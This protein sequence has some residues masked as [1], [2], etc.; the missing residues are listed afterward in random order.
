MFFSFPNRHVSRQ[1]RTSNRRWMLCR[2]VY[3]AWCAAAAVAEFL[4]CRHRNDCSSKSLSETHKN[5]KSQSVYACLGSLFMFPNVSKRTCSTR[6][7]VCLKPVVLKRPGIKKPQGKCSLKLQQAK[8]IWI[9]SFFWY[10]PVDLQVSKIPLRSFLWLLLDANSEG[11]GMLQKTLK[12]TNEWLQLA[13]VI[14]DS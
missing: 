11:Q 2:Q 10:I 14:A 7:L 5:E 4:T 3:F 12:S 6:Q 8:L 1:G 9:S 13:E